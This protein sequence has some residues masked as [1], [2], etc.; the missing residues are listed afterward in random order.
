MKDFALLI[1]VASMVG[2]LVFYTYAVFSGR[3]H[4]LGLKQ[5]SAF[6]LG[7]FLDYYGTRQM[8]LLTVIY[9]PAPEWHNISGYF[10]LRG[11]AFHFLLALT[12]TIFGRAEIANKTF[13]R[14]SLTI[15]WLW[16]FA[17][18]SGALASMRKVGVW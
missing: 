1:A 7:L 16:V 3:K 6:A 8:E 15:Y 18:I 14:V 12:A 2:A 17:F 5:L 13:H 4:G 9:G 11:M 10:S